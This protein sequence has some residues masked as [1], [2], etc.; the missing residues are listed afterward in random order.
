MPTTIYFGFFSPD[1]MVPLKYRLLRPK[2]TFKF[3]T[4]PK[5]TFKM[6]I[7]IFFFFFFFFRSLMNSGLK[8]IGEYKFQPLPQFKKTDLF[9]EI[10]GGRS[11][12]WGHFREKTSRF[13]SLAVLP[14]IGSLVQAL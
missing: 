12:D 14:W 7:S 8:S 13:C 6:R 10:L 5:P 9:S 3:K 1:A 11:S 2:S 4:P